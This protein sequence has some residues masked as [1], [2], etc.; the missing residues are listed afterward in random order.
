MTR[1]GAGSTG[2][3]GRPLRLR[4]PA[5]S[6]NLGCAFDTAAIALRLHL[7]LTATRRS[8]PGLE[9]KYIGPQQE[10]VK[11]GAEN[12]LLRALLAAADRFGADPP[13][14]ALEVRSD[15]PIGVGLGSS[16]AAIVAGVELGARLAPETP[17]L[18][19]KLNLAAELDGHPDNVAA[20]T[21]GGFVVVSGAGE[22][23]GPRTAK[24]HLDD[25]LR[26]VVAIPSQGMATA[27]SRLA[28]PATYPR[29]DVVHNLQRVALL[30]A[31]AFSGEFSFQPE[32][33]DDRLHQ[34]QRAREIP[35]VA[36]CLRIRHPELLGVCLSGSG[37]AVLAV[38]RGSPDIA[39]QLLR[40]AFDRRGVRAST[41]S[42]GGDNA[43]AVWP[44]GE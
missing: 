38:T 2:D 6:A 22:A 4:V 7:E 21:L 23:G 42:L 13:T 32:F 27:K 41:L 39:S 34:P 44:T 43:G 40:E 37:S 15:I 36:E 10:R 18:A 8:R 14:M 28:L 5:T 3:D 24:A 25:D 20:A 33:F 9:L 16:A 19:D 17:L 31:S 35:G 26:F 11:V 12:L 1:Q 30:V 29:E